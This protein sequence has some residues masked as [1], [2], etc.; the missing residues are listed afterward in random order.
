MGMQVS[1]RIEQLNG[2]STTL[3]PIQDGLFCC[4]H[5]D[6]QLRYGVQDR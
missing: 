2:H 4:A 3:K 1:A 6:D 5:E